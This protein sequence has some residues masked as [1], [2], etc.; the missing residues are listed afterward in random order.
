MLED[1]AMRTRPALAVSASAA[2]LTAHC[3][4]LAPSDQA[5]MGGDKGADAGDGGDAGGGYDAV[6]D[7]QHPYEGG[8]SSGGS[9]SSSGGSCAQEADDC[10]STSQCCSGLACEVN[11]GLCIPCTA[12]GSSCYAADDTCCSGTCGSDHMCQ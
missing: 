11:S 8:G 9:G 2:L 10:T 7:W 12:S 5:L 3:S 6:A 4:L 1:L